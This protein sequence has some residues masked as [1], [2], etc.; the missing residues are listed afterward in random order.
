MHSAARY[1][2]CRILFFPLFEHEIPNQVQNQ[3]SC[4]TELGSIVNHV[5]NTL[6]TALAAAGISLAAIFF[7]ILEFGIVEEFTICFT[8]TRL[9]FLEEIRLFIFFFGTASGRFPTNL[10]LLLLHDVNR[11]E[12]LFFP[13]PSTMN[14]T[15]FQ[16]SFDR[17]S[18][19]IV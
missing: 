4:R 8:A 14:N 13:K 7:L 18:T 17:S 5:L 3:E 16:I 11:Y 6:S 1:L 12:Q 9:L 15:T 19:L 10:V 2:D